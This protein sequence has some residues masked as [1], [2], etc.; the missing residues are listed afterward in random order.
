M[1]HDPALRLGMYR[2]RLRAFVRFLWRRFRDDKCFET[3]GALSYTT[4]FAI[5]PMLAAIVAVMSVVPAFSELRDRATRFIFRS[6]VPAA[7]EAVQG[8]L[9]QFAGNASRLTLTGVL[10]LLVSALLMMASI[11]DRFNRIWRVPER[12]KGSARFLMY[13]AALT[14]GPVLFVAGVAASSWVYAQPLWRGVAGHGMGGFRLWALAPFLITWLALA[15]LYIVVPNR[16]ARWREAVFGALLASIL[17]ELVR[18]GFAVYVHA[19]A[20]YREVYGALAAI[21]IFM[22]WIYLSWV[23]VLLGA[24]FSAA[25]AA[26]EYRGEDELLPPGCEFVGLLRVLQHFVAAQREGEGLDEATLTVRE[27][28]LTAELLQR[29]LDDLRRA[30]LIQ[31]NESGA[32]VLARDLGSVHLDDLFR[33]GGYRLPTDALS[34]QAAAVGLTQAAQDVLLRAEAAERENLARPLR[35]LFAP[36]ADARQEEVSP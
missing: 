14:L 27:R 8:Y 12:R 5:V 31:R 7:G 26:F 33:S 22:I 23:I 21:P 15:V 11:E 35:P 18:K 24:T 20:N 32:W 28:F 34:L 10:V 17:F 13:W 3:A 30:G 6:F 9:L 4:L 2:E 25:L 29:Y 19:F 1:N 16:R 36:H